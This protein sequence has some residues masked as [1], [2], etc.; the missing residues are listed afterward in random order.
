MTVDWPTPPETLELAA[1]EVH[2]WAVLLKSHDW[3]GQRE[4]ILS[5]DEKQRAE[6]FRFDVPRNNFVAARAAL[7]TILG[8]YLDLP[9]NEIRFE[10]GP[11]GKPC[12]DGSAGGSNLEFNLAHS[13]EVALVA[14]TG[15][16]EVGV[17]V[18]RLRTVS[19]HDQIA[20]RYFSPAEAAAIA[21]AVED[22]RGQRFLQCWSRKEAVLKM[23]GS[24]IGG[25]INEFEVPTDERAGCWVELPPHG[26]RP[27][28]RCWLQDIDLGTNYAAALA[29]RVER[30]MVCYIYLLR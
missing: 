10:Y 3:A 1:D 18:E 23:L 2:V 28:S 11:N 29:T 12:L 26:E 24:G 17:D 30:R 13:G 27:A 25:P 8:R 14:A 6:E 22:P 5:P 15:G 4:D 21:T 9:P 20:R 7:R 16:C 19:H